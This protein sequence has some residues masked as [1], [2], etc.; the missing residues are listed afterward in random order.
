MSLTEESKLF[1]QSNL[2]SPSYS[3]MT[4]KVIWTIRTLSIELC[5]NKNLLDLLQIRQR[6][7]RSSSRRKLGRKFHRN[8]RS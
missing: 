4:S 7:S 2:S 6:L 8:P 1:S 3:K 5:G